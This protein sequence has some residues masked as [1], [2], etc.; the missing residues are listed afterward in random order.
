MWHLLEKIRAKPVRVRKQIL[1][2]TVAA[3]TSVIFI[4]WVS[5]FISSISPVTAN[6][7]SDNKS[8]FSFLN[9]FRS[10]A[11]DMFE[12]ANKKANTYQREQP[13]E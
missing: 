9:T 6:N 12:T 2:V 11:V 10:A 13:I 3:L 7:A 5:D 1:F 8:A 4:V